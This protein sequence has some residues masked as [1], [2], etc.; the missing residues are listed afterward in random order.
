M[1]SRDDELPL[2]CSLSRRVSVMVLRRQ[3]IALS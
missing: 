3:G 2:N 1:V